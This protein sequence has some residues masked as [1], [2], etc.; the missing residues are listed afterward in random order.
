V[1]SLGLSTVRTNANKQEESAARQ[2][3]AE[4]KDT[5]TEGMIQANQSNGTAYGAHFAQHVD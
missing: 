5:A 1:L 4:L 3:Q 2:G